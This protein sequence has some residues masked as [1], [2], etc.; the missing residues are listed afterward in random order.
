MQD[1]YRID[2]DTFDSACNTIIKGVFEQA[3]HV[4]DMSMISV[5]MRRPDNQRWMDPPCWL[6]GLMDQ[7]E[8]EAKYREYTETPITILARLQFEFIP[9]GMSSM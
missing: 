6:A 4:F 1:W 2:L 8:K 9:R 7:K 5:R 3:P